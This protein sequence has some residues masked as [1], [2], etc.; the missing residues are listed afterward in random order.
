MQ[1]Q[2]R[3]WHLIAKK[4][5]GEANEDELK[6]LEQLLQQNPGTSFPMEQLTHLWNHELPKE[7]KEAEQAFTKHLDRL[8][9]KRAALT[10]ENQKT[11]QA[12]WKDR[13]KKPWLLY[14]FLN[15]NGLVN[16]YFRLIWRGLMRSKVF[17]FINVAGLAVGMASAVLIILW[18]RN[19]ISMDQFHSKKD[20]T[21]LMLNKARFEDEVNVWASTPQPLATALKTEFP[22]QVEDAVRTSWVAV[23]VLKNKDKVVQTEGLLTDSGFLNVFDFPLIKGD[24]YTALSKPHSILITKKL[25]K[26]LFDDEDAMGKTIQV[27]SNVVFTVT[28]VLKDL[29][30]NTSFTFDYLVPWSYMNEIKWENNDWRY[31]TTLTYVLLKKGITEQK[32]N[33]LFKGLK[34]RHIPE[35]NTELLLHPLSK[36]WLYDNYDD[37]GNLSGG[38]IT[39][40]RLFSIIAVFILLIA[41]INYMNLSTARSDKRSKEVGISKIV[42]ASKGSLVL[43]FIGESILVSFFAGIIA[44]A[45]VQLTLP[46]FNDLVNVIPFKQLFV[47]YRD[48]LFWCYAL[49]FIVF[50]GILAGSYPA[51]YL[52]GYKPL[53]VLQRSFKKAHTLVAPRRILVVV[54]FSCAII[55]IISTIII[56]RQ[57]IYGKERDPGY[58]SKDLAFVYVKGDMRKNYEAIKK[59][60]FNKNLITDITRTSSPVTDVWSDDDDYSWAGQDTTIRMGFAQF[61][62][63]NHFIELHNFKMISGRDFDIAK[64]PDDTGA[65]IL[66]EASVKRMGLKQPLGAIIKYQNKDTT[67]WHVIGVIKDFIPEAPFYPIHP[68]VI[69]YGVK[70]FGVINF[71]LNPELSKRSAREKI[72][73][74]FARLNPGYVVEYRRI[75]DEYDHKFEA[76][77]QR[78]KLAALFAGLTIFISCLGLFA[79]AACMAENRIKEIGVRKVLGASVT[80]ITTLLSKDFLKLVVI[81][82]VIASPLAGWAMHNWLKEYPYRVSITWGV[83]ALTGFISLFIAAATVIYQSIKAALANPAKSLRAD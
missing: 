55:F 57:I 64:H 40:V 10:Y 21:Y 47:P 69:H 35:K 22:E 36:L 81:S 31:N 45:L 16:H 1:D 18:L 77:M 49:G 75:E 41:C 58:E 33:E 6:E 79:L 30:N 76:E 73:E 5:A 37:N 66:T 60:L 14:T 70:N 42:G 72:S 62:A 53:R 71:K 24:A 17:S 82:F 29:P 38:R 7:E 28:G 15:N 56:Y 19:E 65:M 51:F 39:S 13:S 78:G 3:I 43:R 25:S 59:E 67:I 63:E 23:L 12:T 80:N 50:T 11:E 9:K 61:E 8:A 32:G 54:Q 2:D 34:N 52:S 27:D 44:L 26:Q 74:V 83:F 68:I 46:F 20:R 4:L 48:P